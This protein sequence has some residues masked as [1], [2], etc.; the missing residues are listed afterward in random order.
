VTALDAYANA[1]KSGV[2]E[3]DTEAFNPV[4][5]DSD[6]VSVLSGYDHSVHGNVDAVL[7]AWRPLLTRPARKLSIGQIAALCLPSRDEL[8]FDEAAYIRSVAAGRTT[9]PEPIPTD[10][11]I[12][13]AAK[14][15]FRSRSSRASPTATG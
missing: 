11:G 10:I 3:I 2:L 4:T 13:S 1:I 8:G 7:D 6:S 15:V 9:P 12:I 14:S 5:C